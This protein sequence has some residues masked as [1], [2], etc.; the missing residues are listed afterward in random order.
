MA[1][2][3]IAG[4]CRHGQKR[5]PMAAAA[6]AAAA[7]A[8]PPPQTLH[9]G[10]ARIGLQLLLQQGLQIGQAGLPVGVLHKA[11]R[12][13]LLWA[14]PVPDAAPYAMRESG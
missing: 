13:G 14:R 7:P 4:N 6:A 9:R 8:P 3:V 1:N 10:V 2:G 12:E 11:Q 5:K